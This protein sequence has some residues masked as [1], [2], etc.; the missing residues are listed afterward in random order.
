S[1]LGAMGAAALLDVAIVRWTRAEWMFPSGA[2]LTGLIVALVLSP[3][4]PLYVP[5]ATAIVA[6]ASKYLIRSRWSN[7]FNPAALALVAAYFVFGGEQ[8]WWGALPNL[9]VATVAGVL[10]GNVWESLRRWDDLRRPKPA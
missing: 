6:I 2:L 3:T 10:V 1:V 5:V 9:P 4:E 8:S 7:V